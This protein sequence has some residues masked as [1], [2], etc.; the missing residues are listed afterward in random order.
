MHKGDPHMNA[1]ELT[2]ARAA[3]QLT[4]ADLEYLNENGLLNRE[5]AGTGT[6]V[7]QEGPGKQQEGAVPAKKRRKRRRVGHEWADVGTLLCADY[8]GVHYEAE[9]VAAPRYRRGRALKLLT[10]PAAGAVCR[11]FSGAMLRA[12]EAQRQE[13]GLGRK[14]AAS[15]WRF[16]RAKGG[17]DGQKR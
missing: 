6:T 14:G 3:S 11:S 1:Q 17:A 7:T 16:W 2:L 13:Q 9:V 5:P 8:H 15:G 4:P 10:G 12:T